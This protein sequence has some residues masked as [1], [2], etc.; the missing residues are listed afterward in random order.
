MASPEIFRRLISYFNYYIGFLRIF[1]L[2][3]KSLPHQVGFVF[4][5]IGFVFYHN[6]RYWLKKSINWVR[7]AFLI[8]R[9]SLGSRRSQIETGVNRKKTNYRPEQQLIVVNWVRF[10]RH[11]YFW[12]KKGINWVRFAY[13]DS[14][15]L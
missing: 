14:N 4:S 3:F 2:W 15:R 6:P 12:A 11:R 9:L 8:R 5:Q 7:F 1:K 10:F 13:F